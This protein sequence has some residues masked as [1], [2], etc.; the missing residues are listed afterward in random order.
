[1]GSAGMETGEDYLTDDLTAQALDY[2][3]ERAGIKDEPFF[4][5]FCHFAVH[6]PWQAKAEDSS[7]FALKDTKGWNG[8]HVPNYAGMILSLDESVFRILDK[9]QETG[10]EEN[11]LVI[12]MSDNGG[13]DYELTRYRMATDNSP[14]RGGKAC[15]TEG[16]IRVP[17]IFR[18][19]GKISEGQWCDVPV[20]CTDL[21]ATIVDAA[22]YDPV[23]YYEETDIDGRSLVPLWDDP[24]NEGEGYDHD[25]RF[26]HY[27]FNVGVLDP[28][29]MKP[30]DPHSAIM[31]DNYKLIFDWH[32]RLR[33]FDL[34]NDIGE[35]H[36]LAFEMPEKTMDLFRKLVS[37]LESEVEEQYWPKLNPDYNP[38][39]QVRKDV[40]FVELI[41]EY[42]EGKD[43]ITLLQQPN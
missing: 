35:E 41:R 2:L 36:N 12:F 4:L 15:L 3:D 23:R 43:I 9:L 14:L 10:L 18:W 38:D 16:G 32:G 25:T 17:L 13:L 5:Y 34:E 29:D 19:K 20:D 8:H 37:W 40:P 42:K 31:E 22:G 27:P 39:L 33:L 30:L 11:T 24:E 26:W 7:Y 1:M 21:F 28:F 6:G